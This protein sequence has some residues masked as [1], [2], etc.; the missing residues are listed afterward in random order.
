[1]GESTTQAGRAVEVPAYLEHEGQRLYT[2]LHPARGARRALLL[3]AGPFGA[4]R[5]RAYLTSVQWARRLAAEGVDVLRFDYR[6]LGE[7]TGDFAAMSLAAWKKDVAATARVLRR[8]DAEAPLILHG[9]RMGGLLAADLFAE[10]LG[11]GLLLWAPPAS[12]REHLWELLRRNV[13][14]E[15]VVRPS[16][17]PKTREAWAAELEA[18]GR[19]VVDGYVW[20][21]ELWQEAGALALRLPAAEEPRPW[22]R[23]DHSSRFWESGPRLVP[24][25]AALFEASE[26]WL[27]GLRRGP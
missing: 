6:G 26:A 12:A 13:I 1:M 25:T 16:G 21:R 4:E 15:M 24:D 27:A 10:G 14:T 7:S 5:E 9:L 17:K 2:V 22:R 11:D 20:T 3:V 19:V 23:F 18:G 8:R